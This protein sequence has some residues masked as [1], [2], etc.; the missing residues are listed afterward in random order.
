MPLWELAPQDIWAQTVD[1]LLPKSQTYPQIKTPLHFYGIFGL[2]PFINLFLSHLLI[3]KT[4]AL[5][6]YRQHCSTPLVIKILLM[7][8]TSNAEKAKVEWFDKDLQDLLELTSK[9]DVLFSIGDWNAK[10]G[11]QEILGV[12]GK[13]GLGIQNEA[14]QRLIRVL[15][16]ECT[17]HSKHPLP[18][19]QEKTLH[20]NITRWSIL[21][22]D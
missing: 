17:G 3:P 14:G 22:S 1:T 4:R 9:T 21:K 19:M 13:F 2:L 12:T 5:P 6:P 10:V 11:S 7:P 15:P 20:I 16:R 18:I 8:L